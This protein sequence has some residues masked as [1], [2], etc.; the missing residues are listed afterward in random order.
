MNNVVVVSNQ[1]AL[2]ADGSLRLI[3]YPMVVHGQYVYFRTNTGKKSITCEV[4]VWSSQCTVCPSNL[5]SL[6][7][8]TLI[9]DCECLAGYS[10]AHGGECLQCVA[11]KCKSGIGSASCQDC[12]TNSLS[13]AFQT[14]LE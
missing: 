6:T 7:G 12:A 8:S 4:Q 2:P 13:V 11:G 5:I 10:G 3:T 9:T 14:P 1:N